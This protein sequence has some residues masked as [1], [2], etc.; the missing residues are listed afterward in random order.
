[1]AFLERACWPHPLDWVRGGAGPPHVG[2]STCPLTALLC[3]CVALSP[4]P[5]SG[6]HP[7]SADRA[8]AQAPGAGRGHEAGVGGTSEAWGGQVCWMHRVEQ[9]VLSYCARKGVP[10]GDRM[11]EGWCPEERGKRHLGSRKSLWERAEPQERPQGSC[12]SG[13]TCHEHVATLPGA[14]VRRAPARGGG[15]LWLLPGSSCR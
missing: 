13:D 6:G 10:Q 2:P 12:G 9:R 11:C 8:G 15:G 1:M 14:W 3:A 7:K 4:T 5:H